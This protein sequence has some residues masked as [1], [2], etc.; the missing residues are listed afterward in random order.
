MIEIIGIYVLGFVVGLFVFSSHNF[1]GYLNFMAFMEAVAWPV[2]LGAFIVG[3]VVMSIYEFFK[4]EYR[5]VSYTIVY[6]DG[7]I[8]FKSNNK[9]FD[10]RLQMKKYIDTL[11]FKNETEFETKRGLK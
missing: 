3:S 6:R 10:S 11:Y 7:Q 2:L 8:K 9:I 4:W 5:G 1:H